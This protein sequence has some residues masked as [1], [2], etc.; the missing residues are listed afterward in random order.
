M[1]GIIYVRV[2]SGEQVAGTS[3]EVQESQCRAYC[4]ERGIDVAAVYKEEGESAK[5]AD[6]TEL[7]R[8]LSYCSE[9]KGQIGAFI[10]AKVDRFARST[11]DHF[12][13]RQQ[14]KKCGIILHSVSEP[15]GDSPTEKFTETL[16]AASA[17]FDNAIRRQRSMD[18]MA[19]RIQQ[20]I[21]PWKPPLGYQCA[22]HRKH[23]EK[24]T[25]VDLPDPG[26]FPIIQ[27]GLLAYAS[28]QIRS[29]TGLATALDSWGLA[30]IRGRRCSP[31]LTDFILSSYLNY[32]SGQLVNPWTGT[33][34][35]G[36]HK[37][38]ISPEEADI[39]RLIR[40][41]R[42]KPWAIRK[43]KQNPE[44]PLR[45]LV[46]CAGCERPFTAGFSRGNGGRYAYYLCRNRKCTSFNRTV[47]RDT[48]NTLAQ[49]AIDAIAPHPRSWHALIDYVTAAVATRTAHTATSAHAIDKTLSE[50]RA[51]RSRIFALHEEGVYTTA[52]FRERLAL[53]EASIAET[54]LASPITPK[55]TVDVV[56]ALSKYKDEYMD[57]PRIWQQTYLRTKDRFERLFLPEGLVY[58]HNRG[59]Q[60]PKLGLILNL[61]QII[62]NHNS[63]T[64]PLP[65]DLLNGIESCLVE[66]GTSPLSALEQQSWL[67]TPK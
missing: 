49:Q 20:G 62:Q 48:L 60:T 17:E 18:G 28:G 67:R 32:Y 55:G 3:L 54:R 38:M 34:H 10:V 57:L 53:M 51:K 58:D 45:G 14:L 7:L 25:R 44:F 39:I 52:M 56:E 47:S 4:A 30:Q 11:E 66:Q 42:Y 24:K 23:D 9:H 6:R 36:A 65:S 12:S 26:T 2:S 13:I 35:K 29:L 22:R 46:R 19:G 33:T 64:V 1:R 8:A 50:L 41:G 31:Q 43:R 61:L 21:Y 59:I 27:R 15:I 5:T 63:S 37:P 40:R 16:L